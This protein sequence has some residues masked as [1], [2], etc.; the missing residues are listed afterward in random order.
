MTYK[1]AFCADERYR[2]AS[3]VNVI[4]IVF[5][6]LTGINIILMYSNTILKNILG[7]K[8]SGFNARTGTYV[9]SVANVLASLFG[10]WVVR[11][12]GRRILLLYGHVGI[13]LAHLLVGIFTVTGV[14][15]GV[16]AMICF[17]LFAY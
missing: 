2:R 7:D 1:D 8:K 13:F 16:L 5:H 4:Y 15:Y 12:F 9:L 11:T 3:W 14:N 17:F 10:I 6:E